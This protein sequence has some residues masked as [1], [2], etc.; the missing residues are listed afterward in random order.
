MFQYDPFYKRS[1]KS[2]Q[3]VGAVKYLGLKSEFQDNV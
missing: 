3:K 1:G 2:D